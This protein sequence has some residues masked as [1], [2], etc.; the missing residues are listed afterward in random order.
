MMNTLVILTILSLTLGNVI[1][2]N[3]IKHSHPKKNSEIC[4]RSSIACAIYTFILAFHFSVRYKFNFCDYHNCHLCIS[5]CIY[6]VWLFER[7]QQQLN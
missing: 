3:I 5:I 7:Q 4:K 2:T 6:F 1:V